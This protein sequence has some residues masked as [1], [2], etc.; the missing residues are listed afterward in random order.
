MLG[1]GEYTGKRYIKKGV[2]LMP[3]LIIG[4]LLILVGLLVAGL[5]V[6]F[7]IGL[8]LAVVGVIVMFVPGS[9]GGWGWP[10]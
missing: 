7:T 5:K 10:R 2:V 6:L 8:I 1:R 3:L 4:I 9:P